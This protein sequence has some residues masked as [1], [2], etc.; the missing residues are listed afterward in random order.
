MYLGFPCSTLWL[1]YTVDFRVSVPASKGSL[2][3]CGS[4]RIT[5]VNIKHSTGHVVS[6][7]HR[8]SCITNDVTAIIII[9]WLFHR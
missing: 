7:E 8:S 9:F 6:G 1:S 4:D 5:E 3:T 2:V